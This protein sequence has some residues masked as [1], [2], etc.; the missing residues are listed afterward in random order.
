MTCVFGIR[1]SGN[2]NL[3]LILKDHSL[4]VETS[5]SDC[6]FLK[7]FILASLDSFEMLFY[8]ISCRTVFAAWAISHVF[9]AREVLALSRMGFFGAWGV[10]G[11]DK[12]KGGFGTTQNKPVY[13]TPHT[14][15]SHARGTGSFT[16]MRRQTDTCTKGGSMD[17]RR[18][19]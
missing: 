6:S 2:P 14:L 18:R 12:V 4:F 10:G 1:E 5:N 16:H 11:R 3:I 9:D 13:K 15:S 7:P 19:R 8:I 17:E